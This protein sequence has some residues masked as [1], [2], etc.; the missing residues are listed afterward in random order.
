MR[1]T[2]M[3][4]V[5]MV[6]LL[7]ACSPLETRLCERLEECS[8]LTDPNVEACEDRIEQ[9]IGSL[10]ALEGS[11]EDE[12]EDCLSRNACA[13]FLNCSAPSCRLP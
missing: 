2:L 8:A 6:S 12:I 4:L 7:T 1:R 5:A 10:G 13:N 11:C 9:Q 3:T